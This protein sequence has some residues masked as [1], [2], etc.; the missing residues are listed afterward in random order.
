MP[1]V[2][3]GK[4]V[5]R[6]KAEGEALVSKQ[7]IGFNLG[8]DAKTGTVT[9]FRHELEGKSVKDKI[10]VFPHG[11]GSTG[12]SFVIY[13]IARMGT[14][15]K[16]M[17]NVKA[18]NI[19]AVGAIMAGIPTVHQLDQDPLA[20]IETGDYVRVD[21]DNGIVEVFKKGECPRRETN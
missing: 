2:L 15:P 8:M 14:G 9:E 16:A 20:V 12:G 3:K 1:I 18:E 10:L 6:G 7:P 11:K 4:C 19:I 17:I 5:C 13:Q 21:A